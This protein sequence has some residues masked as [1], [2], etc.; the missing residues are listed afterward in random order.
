MCRH[1]RTRTHGRTPQ[2]A[3]A[4]TL[5][6]KLAFRIPAR[7]DA[8]SSIFHVRTPSQENIQHG[9]ANVRAQLPETPVRK[10]CWNKPRIF[11]A[12]FRRMFLRVRWLGNGAIFRMIF[13]P[14]GIGNLSP[15]FADQPRWF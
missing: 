3:R 10:D 13:A 11:A 6:E 7:P 9:D 14:I 1:T 8:G 5:R 15:I 12:N 2:T 4:R